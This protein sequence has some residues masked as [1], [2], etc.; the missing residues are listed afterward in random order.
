MIVCGRL[1]DKGV[2]LLQDPNT[3]KHGKHNLCIRFVVTTVLIGPLIGCG[4]R[5]VAPSPD[6]P[7]KA[8]VAEVR[9]T[10]DVPSPPLPPSSMSP[11]SSM[12]SSQSTP[13]SPSPP[14]PPEENQPVVPGTAVSVSEDNPIQGGW[15]SELFAAQ[16]SDQ[17][18][19]LTRYLPGVADRPAEDLTA[20]VA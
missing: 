7:A 19:R 14:R 9:K 6:S 5:E 18:K 17:L 13:S 3:M 16:V 20:I 2:S 8:D 15:Q 11:P 10:V 1:L 4:D 12:L